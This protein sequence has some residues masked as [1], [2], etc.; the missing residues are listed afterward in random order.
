VIPSYPSYEV[1]DA[2][3]VRRM[4]H[5][6]ST[7]VG[8]IKNASVHSLGYLLLGLYENGRRSNVFAH[9]AVAAAFLGDVTDKQINHIDGNKKNNAVSNLE[10]TDAAGNMAHAVANGLVA[11]GSRWR[12][13]KQL[14]KVAR[15]RGDGHW[16][17]HHPELLARGDQNGAVKHP[18]RLERGE[19]R[20]CAVLTEDKVRQIR[21]LAAAG[22][23]YEIIA[24]TFGVTRQNIRIIVNRGSWR[25][26]K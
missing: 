18:E 1:S 17:R 4:A 20:H 6:P 9:R 15:M 24:R 11:S 26:V 25:H 21:I 2:G 8:R 16:T 13:P 10:L 5:G 12:T 14:A 22:E 23:R 7:H 3:R 19:Q